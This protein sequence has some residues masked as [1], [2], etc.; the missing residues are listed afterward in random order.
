MSS[1]D[2]LVAFGPL[3][4]RSPSRPPTQQELYAAAVG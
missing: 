3:Y 1:R 4:G 2:N